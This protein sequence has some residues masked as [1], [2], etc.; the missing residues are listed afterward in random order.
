MLFSSLRARSGGGR[1][2]A[3]F[4]DVEHAKQLCDGTICQLRGLTQEWSF[5]DKTD[6][7]KLLI[8]PALC[9]VLGSA[10]GAQAGCLIGAAAGAAVGHVAG[11]HALLGAAAGCA[12]GHH[13]AAKER[14]ANDANNQNNTH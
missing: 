3:L 4:D 12:I 10:S 9:L 11:H 6:M 2:P 13:H 8:I 7:K 14:R 5:K 1:A